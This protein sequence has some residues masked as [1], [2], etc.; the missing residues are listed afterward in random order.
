MAGG[1]FGMGL[2]RE[3]WS[4]ERLVPPARDGTCGR[5][6]RAPQRRPRAR[7][8]LCSGTG[9]VAGGVF[10]AGA[11]ERGIAA[12]GTCAAGP[13]R[14]GA[15]KRKKAPRRA[16][17]TLLGAGKMSCTGEKLGAK[18]LY[19]CGWPEL[20]F[21]PE[22]GNA[23]RKAGGPAGGCAGDLA[24][25]EAGSCAEGGAWSGAGGSASGSTPL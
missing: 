6:A 17:A 9:G 20:C 7:G 5:R 1:V 8:G 14:D 2:A 22:G 23:D 10:G 24:G 25:S 12:G 19:C 16:G 18:R 4:W 11:G 21:R 15:G 3:D 13:G